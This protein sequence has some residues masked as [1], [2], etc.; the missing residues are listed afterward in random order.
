MDERTELGASLLV[1]GRVGRA[2][3]A[4]VRLRERLAGIPPALNASAMTWRL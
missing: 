4:R 1:D 3:C 2:L